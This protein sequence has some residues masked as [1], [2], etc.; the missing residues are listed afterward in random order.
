M[1][2]TWITTCVLSDATMTN[3]DHWIDMRAGVLDSKVVIVALVAVKYF[4]NKHR[5]V[6]TVMYQLHN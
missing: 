4:A 2:V 5:I 1:D 3:C 6:L